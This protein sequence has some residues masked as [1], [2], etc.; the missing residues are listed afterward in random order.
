MSESD[1]DSVPSRLIYNTLSTICMSFF[2]SS[3]LDTFSARQHKLH[4]RKEHLSILFTCH[5]QQK[6]M[7]VPSNFGWSTFSYDRNRIMFVEKRSVCKLCIIICERLPDETLWPSGLRR[8]V[9]A[10][11][12]TGVGSNPIEVKFCFFSPFC[13]LYF[14]IIMPT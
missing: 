9:K 10:V 3:P 8:Y 2:E 4:S 12:F 1:S 7:F 13:L 6:S 14:N 5:G 11:V